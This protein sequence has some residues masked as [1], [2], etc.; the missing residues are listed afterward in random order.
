MAD[1]S[2]TYLGL[3]LKNPLIVSSCNLTASVEKILECESAG[4]GAVVLKSLF[5][6][7]IQADT[8]KM[9]ESVDET[10]VSTQYDYLSKTG[11]Y[12]Y[13]DQ[14]L[15]L[16]EDAKAQVNIPIIASVN[17]VSSGSWIDYAQ[18]LERLGADA[19][20]LNMFLLPAD[21][22]K[23]GEE[24]EKVYL[25][26]CR[27]IKRKLSIPFSLKLGFHFSGLANMIKQLAN[28]GASGFVLFN[29]FYQPDVDIEKMKI[30]PA[31]ILSAPEEMAQSLR[32]I[33][34][35]SGEIGADF[36]AGTGVHD[37]KSVIKQLLVGASA[38][39]ICSILLQNG[40][41]YIQTLLSVVSEWMDRH[42]YASLED[43]KGVLCQEESENPEIYE[44]AQ[45][46]KALV[47]IS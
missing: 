3:K 34:L 45:Y 43:Y 40:L 33:A 8:A 7:Q 36:A 46:V 22:G 31:R 16:L 5:E 9:M 19:L 30:V 17:C 10:Q 24:L 44:R 18:R 11:N 42:G 26:V 25:D 41:G 20:E 6:E 23:K 21:V 1:L 2:T 15:S 12:H 13:I 32:W 37:G 28:E 39:Q 35:L 47:G 27:K 4:A 29:R 38:I 14:Y